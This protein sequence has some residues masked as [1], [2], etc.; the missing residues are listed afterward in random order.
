MG[1]RR[2]RGRASAAPTRRGRAARLGAE[3]LEDVDALEEP[4]LLVRLHGG[5]LHALEA[6]RLLGDGV[7]ALLRH[8]GDVGDLL[9]VAAA[10]LRVL[11]VALGEHV[12]LD[13]LLERGQVAAALV[14]RRA[15]HVRAVGPVLDGRVARHAGLAAEVVVDRAVHVAD[16]NRGVPLVLL[17]QGVPRRFHRLAVP[18]PGRQELDKSVLAA[19]EDLGL[20][21]VGAELHGARRRE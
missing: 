15:G 13:V 2:R 8:L 21:V 14:G 6:R 11:G 9:V 10:V 3:A 4:G 5:A 16:Q 17:H 20:E 18:S 1:S 12:V 7:G 19:L